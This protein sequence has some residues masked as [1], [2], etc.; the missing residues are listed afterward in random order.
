MDLAPGTAHFRVPLMR[1]LE[2][3]AQV[4]KLVSGLALPKFAVD[5]P[6]GG[7]KIL[8]HEGTIAGEEPRPEGGVF[9]LKGPDGRL[10]P[11]PAQ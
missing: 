9:L 11:Y 4:K 10:W 3:Y 8:L 2:I 1:S 5:L 6:G 7:G